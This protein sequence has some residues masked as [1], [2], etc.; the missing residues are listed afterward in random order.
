MTTH[1]TVARCSFVT[2]VFIGGLSY[3]GNLHSLVNIFALGRGRTKKSLY[4]IFLVCEQLGGR[5]N[6]SFPTLFFYSGDQ[7]T[8]TY[9]ILWARISPHWLSELIW[10]WMSVS[11]KSSVW[12]CFPD[13]LPHYPW[14]AQSAH[15]D[16]FRSRVCTCLG[17]T[18]YLANIKKKRTPVIWSVQQFGEK[19]FCYGG[20]QC[21]TVS[22]YFAA[23]H[24]L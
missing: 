4:I 13:R 5:F 7:L 11:L 16:F 18:C 6:D 1:D 20:R 17:V 15:F 10:L 8:C 19:S 3:K 24:S 12:V 22:A 9:S 21:Q 2:G 23:L 14:T